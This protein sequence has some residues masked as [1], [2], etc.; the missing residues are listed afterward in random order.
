MTGALKRSM[1]LLWSAGIALACQQEPA[2]EQASETDPGI[3]AAAV[4]EAI[5]AKDRLFADAM[6]AGDIETVMSVYADDAILLPPH[7]PRVEGAAAIRETFTS[8][9]EEGGPPAS[10]TI[11][12][13]D[14]TVAAAGDYAHAVGTWT[15]SGPGPDGSMW[16]DQGNVLVVWKNIE[17]DWKVVTDIWNSENPPMGTEPMGMESEDAMPQGAGTPGE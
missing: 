16:S 9:F 5:A 3:D 2:T 12:S 11:T 7:A 14:V 8:W 17:G 6:V 15:M 10:M 4:T 13:D 1:V